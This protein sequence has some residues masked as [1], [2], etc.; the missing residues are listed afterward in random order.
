MFVVPSF[1]SLTAAISLAPSWM[2]VGAQDCSAYPEGAHTGEVSAKLLAELG[3]D[4]VELGHAEL[5]AR[6]DNNFLISKKVKQ[7]TDSGLDV[8]LCIGETRSGDPR[9]AAAE[10]IMQIEASG[11]TADNA[12]IAYEPVW[13]IGA[14]E[15]ASAKHIL[16]TV[17]II[18]QHLGANGARVIYGGAAGSG[19]FRH[20][21]PEV[22]GLFL[23]RM[24][25]QPQEFLDIVNEASVVIA[26]SN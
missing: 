5:R 4:F 8:L 11:V 10:C 22:G 19:L 3:V 26:E 18:R 24:A 12:L 1:P 2:L 7:A 16:G 13:A 14:D 23:G 21:Y 17:E 25:H 20:V 6:G 15:P 9:S